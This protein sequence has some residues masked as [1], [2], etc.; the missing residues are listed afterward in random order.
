MMATVVPTALSGV[1]G[2]FG[3]V[4]VVED[5]R[6]AADEAIGPGR[7]EEAAA[8]AAGGVLSFRAE[9]CRRVLTTEQSVHFLGCED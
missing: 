2:T 6:A 3:I 5:E 7:G 1:M 8:A 9:S 4:V